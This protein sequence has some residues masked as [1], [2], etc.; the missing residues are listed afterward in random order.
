R[1]FEVR[2][3]PARDRPA[4]AGPAVKKFGNSEGKERRRDAGGDQTAREPDVAERP[5]L[6]FGREQ[7]LR[8]GTAVDPASHVVVRGIRLGESVGAATE[9]RDRDAGGDVRH[10]ALDA[11][12]PA[13][14]LTRQ[15]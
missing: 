3:M 10:G 15:R 8:I 9:R 7:P 5:V 6:L 1:S 2:I 13:L 11:T 4:T 12:G 14:G